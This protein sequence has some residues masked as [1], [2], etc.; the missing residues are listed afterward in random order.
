M[1]GFADIEIKPRRADRKVCAHCEATP[2]SCRSREWLSGRRC[3]EAC[4]GNHD[5]AIDQPVP[6]ERHLGARDGHARGQERRGRASSF[7][8]STPL[9]GTGHHDADTTEGASNE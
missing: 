8:A 4:A 3:C 9:R 2:A 5:D 1:T 7:T 6:R